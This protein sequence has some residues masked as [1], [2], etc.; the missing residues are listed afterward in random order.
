M[1]SRLSNPELVD[2]MDEVIAGGVWIPVVGVCCHGRSG[3]F[4]LTSNGAR[5]DAGM[6]FALGNLI[7]VSA[8]SMA[9]SARPIVLKRFEYNRPYDRNVE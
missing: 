5:A 3:N 7:P 4:K 8:T 2:V 9:T 6:S 1:V